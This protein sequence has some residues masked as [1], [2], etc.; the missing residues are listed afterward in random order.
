MDDE[1][2]MSMSWCMNWEYTHTHS[3]SLSL[4]VRG[5]EG[6]TNKR[7]ATEEGVMKDAEMHASFSVDVF[8]LALPCHIVINLLIDFGAAWNDASIPK[9]HCISLRRVPASPRPGNLHCISD[10]CAYGA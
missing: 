1:T 4:S 9:P 8:E 2:E 3:L 6:S 7:R 5:R 10:G